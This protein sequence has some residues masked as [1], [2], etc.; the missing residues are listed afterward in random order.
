MRPKYLTIEDLDIKHMMKNKH[1]AELIAEQCFYYFIQFL[2]Y[3][4]KK[5]KIELRIADRFYPSSKTCNSCGFVH[6]K[7]K[8][9]DRTFQ[10]PQCNHTEDRDFNAAKNLR[11]TKQY[12]LAS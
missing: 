10:C 6:R 7:L 2:K 3:Q 4:A 12:T 1:L 11:H 9:S 8:L 5:Y